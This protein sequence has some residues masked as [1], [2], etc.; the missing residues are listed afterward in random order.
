MS[1]TRRYEEIAAH[2]RRLIQDGELAP[3]GAMPSMRKVCEETG[4]AMNTV[5]RAFRILQDEGLTKATSAGT[6]VAERSDIAVTGA[7]RLR[8]IGRTGRRYAHRETSTAHRVMVRSC[9]DP[10]IVEQLD[11]EP[12]DEIII[13]TRV[14]L[15]DGEPTIVALSC[16]HMRAVLEVPE[17]LQDERL[18]KFWQELYTERTGKEITR[19]PERRRARLASDDELDAFKIDVPGDVAVPVLELQT[20]FHTEDGP[21][22]V[23]QDVYAPGLWQV[24]TE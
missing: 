12:H 9:A 1:P 4:A 16:I 18:P 2:Y 21:I 20:T 22:E 10:E 5:S 14:F 19:S 3:G 6:V 24:D 8:R 13:R 23:W 7:A 11:I 15:R 17:L